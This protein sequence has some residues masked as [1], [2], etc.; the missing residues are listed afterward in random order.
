LHENQREEL[1]LTSEK[2][3]YTMSEL[4]RR[5][6]EFINKELGGNNEKR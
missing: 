2:T 4:I 5:G 3:G 1:K 6:I